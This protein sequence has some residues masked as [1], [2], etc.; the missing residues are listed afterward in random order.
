MTVPNRREN[1]ELEL[2]RSEECW[3]AAL[4]LRDMGLFADAV[5]RAYYSILHCARAV[6]LT[7]GLESRTHSGVI[8][9]FNLHFV[10]KGKITSQ[11]TRALTQLQGERETADYDVTACYA[12]EE[13]VEILGRVEDFRQVCLEFLNQEGWLSPNDG[14]PNEA[15]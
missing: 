8:T 4:G 9:L 1:L 10:R 13:V 6:L 14:Q 5:S 2:S 7:E 11:T 12:L 3:R 15:P